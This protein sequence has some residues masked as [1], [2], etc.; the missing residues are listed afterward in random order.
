MQFRQT[1]QT[2]SKSTSCRLERLQSKQFRGG[3]N[4]THISVNQQNI[5]IFLMYGI[6]RVF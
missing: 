5:A 6:F 2:D 3:K 1:G 4:V